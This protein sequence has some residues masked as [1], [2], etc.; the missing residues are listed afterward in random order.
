MF[1]FVT[2]LRH[3]RN[4]K[5]VAM[6]LALLERTLETIEAQTNKNYSVTVVCHEIPKLSRIF[7]KV[8]FLIVDFEPPAE[9]F[10]ALAYKESN[11]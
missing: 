8:E 1:A 3:P 10:E 5:S 2:C 7:P 9:N 11:N 6:T 4:M